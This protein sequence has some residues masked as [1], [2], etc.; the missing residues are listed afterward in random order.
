MGV[1]RV[2]GSER[3]KSTIYVPEEN[4]SLTNS[5]VVNRNIECR[6]IIIMVMK[7]AC[8]VEFHC[9]AVEYNYNDMTVWT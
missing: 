5:P 9:T 8:D 1:K 4:Q 2:R 6:P 3:T 7:R